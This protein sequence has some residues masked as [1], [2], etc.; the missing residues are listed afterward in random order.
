MGLLERGDNEE[1]ITDNGLF[2]PRDD[3]LIEENEISQIFRIDIIIFRFETPL[4]EAFKEFNY[5]SQIDVDVL[6]KDIHGFKT[7]EE[8]KD[9]WI[10]EW[11]DGIPWVNE[12]PWT[13]DGVWTE[14]INNICHEF[15]PLC[16]KNR[17]AKWP[18]CNWKEDGYCN[19]GDLPG[20]VREGNSIRY[21]DYEWYHTIKDS[22]LKEKAL[23]NK[24]ILEESMN[25]ME[26]SS[27]DEWDHDL[28]IDEWKDYEHTTYIKTDV[29]SN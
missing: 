2:N 23:I 19:T 7:Y 14:P 5:L 15:N 24:I 29:S 20:F 6:I 10:Y 3:N 8:Y 4:C 9:E 21:E 17:T 26:E 27:N 11:N 12:K 16:F 25:V 28:P 13:D 18:T 1:V 22:E